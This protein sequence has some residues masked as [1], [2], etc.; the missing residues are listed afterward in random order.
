MKKFF[1]L[2]A[3]IAAFAPIASPVASAGPAKPLEIKIS[4]VDL[5][6]NHPADAAVMIAR[7]EAAIRPICVAPGFATRRP[8]AACIRDAVREAVAKTKIQQLMTA[9]NAPAA[10]AAP[11]TLLAQR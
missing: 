9:F 3:L 8:T 7:L 11:A 5:D 4:A 1:A 10:P 2:A 6:L